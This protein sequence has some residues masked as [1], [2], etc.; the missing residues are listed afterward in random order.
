MKLFKKILRILVLSH[1]FPLIGLLFNVTHDLPHIKGYIVGWAIN[2]LLGSIIVI[3]FFLW[4][5]FD[6]D[7]YIDNYY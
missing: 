6:D 7:E 4:W 3:I 5:L 2:G 1:I